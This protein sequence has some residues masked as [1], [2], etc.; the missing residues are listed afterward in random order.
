MQNIFNILVILHVAGGATGLICGT[1]A[2]AVVKGRKAHLLNGKIFSAAMI[3]TALSALIMSKLPGHENVFLFAVGGFTLYMVT[4]GYRIVWL[5][6]NVVANSKPFTALD[7]GLTVFGLL[8]G[9]FMLYLCIKMIMTNDLFGIVP[10]V[11]GFVCIIYAK[12]D[13]QLLYGKKKIKAAWMR[14]HIIR[15][16]GALIASYTAFLVVNVQVEMQWI[17]WLLPTMIGSALITYFIKRFSPKR[18]T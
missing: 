14:N 15:M 10:G 3:I 1:I 8:F 13:Y 12:M 5:K 17:L 9:L 7:Y 6:R 18:K 4:T 11:F 16:M 2:A